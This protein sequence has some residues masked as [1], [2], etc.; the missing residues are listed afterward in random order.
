MAEN[1]QLE[2]VPANNPFRVLDNSGKERFLASGNIGTIGAAFPGSEYRENIERYYDMS[3]IVHELF[4]DDYKFMGMLQK[5]GSDPCGD[6][7]FNSHEKKEQWFR[8][9]GNVR[10][11]TTEKRKIAVRPSKTAKTLGVNAA[12]QTATID[13]AETANVIFEGALL[14]GVD[15]FGYE[16]ANQ[17]P[18]W[19]LQYHQLDITFELKALKATKHPNGTSWV[20]NQTEDVQ[21]SLWIR[22]DH[23]ETADGLMRVEADIEMIDGFDR[24]D[25]RWGDDKFSI[26]L[27]ADTHWQ[28]VGRV[29]PEGSGTVFGWKDDIRTRTNWMQ[30]FR[31]GTPK[32]TGTLLGMD[33]KL[34]PDKWQDMVKKCLKTHAQDKALASWFGQGYYRETF[35]KGEEDRVRQMWGFIPYMKNWGFKDSNT[36]QIFTFDSSTSN[37]EDFRF[38]LN[39]FHDPKRGSSIN[40]NELFVSRDVMT[41]FRGQTSA[42]KY[43]N[44]MTGQSFAYNT[45]SI[46]H[47]ARTTYT[48]GGKFSPTPPKGQYVI[49][50]DWGHL[51]VTID[52]LFVGPYREICAL[53]NFTNI[54]YKYLANGNVRRHDMYMD[55][56]QENG[57]DARVDNIL[58]ECGI[59]Y[60]NPETQAVIKIVLPKRA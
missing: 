53:P 36:D 13:S 11:N 12:A 3:P 58:S 31:N 25:A 24:N 15:R 4:H 45:A 17:E 52:E 42:T 27:K 57:E 26:Q 8:R 37:I 2:G 38:F 33:Y 56:I 43:S 9:Y 54:R 41:W 16:K 7:K 59:E 28:I 22:S 1:Y 47:E 39:E 21:V 48:P 5:A 34:R 10:L 60:N 51:N 50:T 35:S 30:I 55:M 20:A 6:I 46:M 19:L 40:T 18:L 29:V 44:G 14:T 32:V 23:T 49:D